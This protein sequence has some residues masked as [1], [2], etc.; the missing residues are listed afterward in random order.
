MEGEWEGQ[1]AAL[2]PLP[3]VDVLW[4]RR[5]HHLHD[6]VRQEARMGARQPGIQRQLLGIERLGIELL[7][8][9]LLGIERLGIE[10]LLVVV[11]IGQR[12]WWRLRWR[13]RRRRWRWIERFLV[14]RIVLSS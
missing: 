14:S 6:D 11:L 12:R 5:L 3:A 10:R 7:G 2:P 1:L 13:W 4:H 9:E 8:I